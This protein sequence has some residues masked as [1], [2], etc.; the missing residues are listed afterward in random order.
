MTAR[1]TNRRRGTDDMKGAN[2]MMKRFVRVLAMLLALL[3]V[4]TAAVFATD[5]DGTDGLNDDLDLS[6]QI[7]P[8][9]AEGEIPE[10]EPELPVFPDVTL[11]DWFYDDVLAL[12]T[13]GVVAGYGDGT[14]RPQENVTTGAALKMI[15]LAAGYDEPETVSSHWARGYLNLALDE[16]LLE[17][18]E[19]TDLDVSITRGLMAKIAAL[20]LELT[21]TSEQNV[22]ADATDDYTQALYESGIVN[23]YADNTFRPE[24]T[25]TRAELSAI[26]HRINE[27]NASRNETL[28]DASDITLRTTQGGIEFIKKA[29]GFVEKPMWD[30]TQYSVGY[31]SKC[32][33]DDYPDG[34]TREEADVLLRQHLAK[35][36]TELD[37]YEQKYN[38]SFTSNQYDALVSFTYNTGSYWMRD[39][40]VSTC[41]ISGSYT[42]NELASAYGIWCHVG[43]QAEIHTG[44]I[45]RRIREL[46]MFLYNDYSASDSGFSYVIFSSDRGEVEVDVAVYRTGSQMDPYFEASAA[47]EIFQGW[48]DENG[49]SYTAGSVVNGNL[50]LSAVWQ[51]TAESGYWTDG[52]GD[53]SGWDDFG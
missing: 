15:L 45:A 41:L 40:R 48:V 13:A 38:L 49:V 35:I 2:C 11:N 39:S 36:E 9:P 43:K 23:G 3:C 44:L 7:D 1:R 12:Y 27:Y 24:R 20:A 17:K 14:F 8:S 33:K 32:S 31:G 28:P 52:S 47:G 16:Q 30:Y 37:A 10:S 51:S 19:I 50:K 18:G 29:E 26:V 6:G 46:K 25:L 53:Y 4:L 34:I 42:E 5:T 21:R 22:F